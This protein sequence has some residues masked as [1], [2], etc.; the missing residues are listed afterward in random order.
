[1]STDD[2]LCRADCTSFTNPPTYTATWGSDN[3]PAAAGGTITEP[4][5]FFTATYSLF[6]HRIAE[7]SFNVRVGGGPV[8][9]SAVTLLTDDSTPTKE[10][11]ISVALG[12]ISVRCTRE[13]HAGAGRM[14]D[15]E[16]L[17][18]ER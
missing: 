6:V 7:S 15:S 2:P 14:C 5:I 16:G 12:G 1:M 11:V 17:G 18:V 9:P 4:T 13:W 3:T 10:L 8:S